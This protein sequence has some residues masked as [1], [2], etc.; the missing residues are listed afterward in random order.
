[1]FR[2]G[3]PAGTTRTWPRPLP[4]RRLRRQRPRHA[5]TRCARAR[6]ER[7]VPRSGDPER[8]LGPVREPGQRPTAG[9]RALICGAFHLERC[10]IRP[11]V[12]AVRCRVSV[13]R[14]ACHHAP[15]ICIT[16]AGRADSDATTRARTIDG[17]RTT[18]GDFHAQAADQTRVEYADLVQKAA[19][20]DRQAMEQLLMRVQEVAYRFSLL[21]CGHPEDAEDVMQDALLKTYQH[22]AGID[23]PEA[24]RT[25]L[26]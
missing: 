21:V 19:E 20:G 6:P 25:W 18:R 8:R 9:P 23:H 16:R 2:S 15:P 5:T 26:Y 1:M 10:R 22:V 12:T 11:K 17:V 4:S 24:F 3:R 7:H 14:C 13:T